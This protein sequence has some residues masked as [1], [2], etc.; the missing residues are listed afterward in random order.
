[1]YHTLII[2]EAGVNHNG[3]LELAKKL[4]DEA[5]EAGADIVKF[6]TFKASEIAG[7]MAT[8][9]EYQ[10]KQTDAAESQVAMLKRLELNEENHHILQ[11]YCQTKPI[12]FLS[13]PFDL[14]SID[15]LK[16]MGIKLGKIPS[17]ELTNLP[18]LRKMAQNFE[19]II[20][21]TGMATLQEIK[22]SVAILLQN[23]LKKKNP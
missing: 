23:G 18:Y 16:K 22:D 1:M 6:Q 4:I 17:G 12:E 19:Q 2:A 15:L 10:K 20:L 13:T 14:S 5:F 7:K 21:S 8:K 11:D 3:S 9:A